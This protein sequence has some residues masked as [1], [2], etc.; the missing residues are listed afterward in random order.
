MKIC[1]NS[2]NI[3]YISIFT[4]I[5]IIFTACENTSSKYFEKAR[6]FEEKGD[7]TRAVL[8]YEQVYELFPE[9]KEAAESLFRSA[10]INRIYLGKA[11]SAISYL[12]AIVMNYPDSEYF[13]SAQN[14]IGDIYMENLKN[15]NQAISEYSKL[16]QLNPPPEILTEARLKIAKCFEESGNYEQALIELRSLLNAGTEL[17]QTTRELVEYKL[18]VLLYIKK[19]LKSSISVLDEFIKKYPE[20]DLVPDAKFY[21]ASAYAD[22]GDFKKALDLLNAIENT[23]R[24][25]EAVRT[26]IQGLEIRMKKIKR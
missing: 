5:L 16:I 23:Y 9:S 6:T 12:K 11:R 4:I 3:I 10:R 17:T 8:Y 7:Y 26:K 25:S 19:E 15:Y 21:L 13:I 2:R 1:L 24:N 22:S 18:G 14:E 20:S